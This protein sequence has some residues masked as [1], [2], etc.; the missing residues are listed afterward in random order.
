METIIAF[1]LF[2]VNLGISI[3]NAYAV[4]YS[5]PNTKVTGGWP[6]FVAWC[7]AIMSACGF[8]WCYLLVLGL[9]AGA[10]GFLPFEY[11]QIA[12]EIGYVVIIIPIIGSGLG[13]WAD[14]VTLAWRRRDMAS[15]GV[16]GWNTFA[17]VYNIYEATTV[18]PGIFK[19]LTSVFE[20]GDDEDSIFL[21]LALLVVAFALLGGILTATI[22]IR[23][24][25][26]KYAHGELTKQ[27]Y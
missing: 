6:R 12:F 14:S 23:R 22:I 9:L 26:R 25:A 27:I 4:G 11:V 17:N 18:L 3:F 8:T 16:A 5:W 15:I 10:T 21:Y 13:I 7:G 2:F 20:D 19:H 1:V 24:T